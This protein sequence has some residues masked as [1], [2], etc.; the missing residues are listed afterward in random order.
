[1]G[2][3]WRDDLD[4]VQ[5]TS[6]RGLEEEVSRDGDPERVKEKMSFF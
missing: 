6:V 3:A 5:A 1:M 4:R 2:K